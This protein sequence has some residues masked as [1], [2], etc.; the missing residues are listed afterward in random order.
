VNSIE[1][2]CHNTRMV[3]ICTNT[4]TKGYIRS[5]ILSW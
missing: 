3:D 4:E 2:I 5:L 1:T